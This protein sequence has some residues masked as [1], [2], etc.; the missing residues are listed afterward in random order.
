[1]SRRAW[2][3]RRRK[4]RRRSIIVAA[5][6][7]ALAAGGVAV[8]LTRSGPVR[9][10][11]YHEAT[12]AFGADSY[13]YLVHVPA[14]YRP[15]RAVPLIVVL[16]GCETT[17]AQQAEVSGYAPIADQRRLIVLYPEVDPSDVGNGGCWKGI[18][19]PG[20]EGAARGD[21]GAIAAMTRAVMRTWRIDPGRVY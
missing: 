9:D 2:P 12:F 5:C 17:A 15:A 1:M 18:W 6:A 13:S 8:A 10:G 11:R 20:G 21:A 19:E 16:H 14:T 4:T 7:A 3:P